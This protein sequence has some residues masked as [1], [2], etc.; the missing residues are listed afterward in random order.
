MKIRFKFAI[1]WM[2]L[3]LSCTVLTGC[4]GGSEQ[5]VP[6]PV[7]TPT[8]TP[9]PTPDP[10]P[11]PEDIRLSDFTL[12]KADNPALESDVNF[13]L[14]GNQFIGSVSNL[15]ETDSLIATFTHNGT[16]VAID[17]TPQFSG[18]TVNDFS[19]PL[20]YTVTMSDGRTQSYQVT[21]AAEFEL[22]RIYISTD[23]N[24]PIDSKEEYVTG[25]VRIE[26][27]NGYEGLSETNMQIRGRGNSTWLFPKKPY[28]MK[29]EEK[30]S[31]LNMP[32]DRKWIFLAE[33]SDKTLLRNNIAFEMGH[34]SQLDWTPHSTFAEVYLNNQYNGTY[35]ITQ[36][37]EET[38]NRV[39]LGDDGYLLEID[40]LDRL[41]PDDVYFESDHFLIN[42]KEPKLTIDSAAYDEAVAMIDAFES[43]LF[44]AQFADPIEGY[45][46]LIDVE[47]F[48]DWYLINEITKN[49]DSWGWSS[50]YLNMMPGGP[51]KMGP[52]WDYDLSFGNVDY[53]DSQYTEGFWVKDFNVWFARL[54]QDDWFVAQVQ[55]RFDYFQSQQQYIV[56][57]IDSTAN[58][59]NNAQQNNDNLWQTLG[60]YV[61][62][63][64][65]IFDTYAEEV[66]HLKDWYINRMDWLDTA[67]NNL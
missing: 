61:W 9:E 13:E 38:N 25:N 16:S 58:Y 60:V 1:G 18:E 27:M 32:E 40:Q 10:T 44:S 22:P 24:V 37:V 49:V 48:I 36:K 50:I 30:T 59:L 2:A 47:S 46:A 29:F 63:N 12:I 64:P 33:F 67:L 54:F 31:I 14:N 17:G 23:G 20:T 43:A 11:E 35:H 53:A 26:G 39:A 28:Q 19:T 34:I 66:D 6:D 45:R 62:P 41:D 5:P 7:P 56:N 52:L 21:L 42:I 3:I 8:P 57:K 65:V 55:A 15:V 4:G 51:I